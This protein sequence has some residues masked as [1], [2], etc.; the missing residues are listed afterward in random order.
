M[1]TSFFALLS[2]MK[3]IARWGLMRNTRPENL[4]EHSYETAVLAH[5]L[6]VIGNSRFGKHYDVERAVL[7]ALYHDAPEIFTGDMPTPVKYASPKL[8]ASYRETETQAESR[9]L[10]CLP[11]DIRPI[12]APLLDG[13]GGDADLLRLVKAADK[14]SALIKCIDEEKAGNT[15]FRKAADAQI[16]YLKKMA[17]P[18]ADCFLS[19]FLPPYRLTLDEQG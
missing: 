8:R 6:A 16:G 10:A 1:K 19:E 11:D 12:Y 9:L 18:E 7:L 4:M 15:E 3:Y 14:L 2:R 13:S 5:A 17:M